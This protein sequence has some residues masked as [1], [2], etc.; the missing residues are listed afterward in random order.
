MEKYRIKIESR[1]SGDILYYPEVKQS[2]LGRWK[3]LDESGLVRFS[4]GV[5]SCRTMEMAK[6]YIDSRKNCVINNNT[7]K[8]EYISIL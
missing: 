1:E 6:K 2:F 5:Y 3:P 7:I 8:V 4:N